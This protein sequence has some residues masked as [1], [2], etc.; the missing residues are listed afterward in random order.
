MRIYPIITFISCLIFNSVHTTA[1]C[2]TDL[3]RENIKGKVKQIKTTATYKKDGKDELT[4]IEI[5]NYDEMGKDLGY[6][7]A[8][9]NNNSGD[10]VGGYIVPSGGTP[11]GR[12]AA[13]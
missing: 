7:F 12:A 9:K 3:E 11:G 5:K 13:R 4:Y 10:L 6:T 8:H 2:K 1:Q